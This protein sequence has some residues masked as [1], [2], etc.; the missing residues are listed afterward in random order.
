MVVDSDHHRTTDGTVGN[1]VLYYIVGFQI[2]RRGVLGPFLDAKRP[3]PTCPVLDLCSGQGRL[4]VPV[5]S[6]INS[7]YEWKG[8]PYTEDDDGWS[9]ESQSGKKP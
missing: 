7:G 4:S 5:P 8:F 1:D 2:A 9:E 6:E 3:P